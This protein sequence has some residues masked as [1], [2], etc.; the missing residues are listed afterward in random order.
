[1][2]NILNCGNNFVFCLIILQEIIEHTNLV[3]KYLQSININY[4]IMICNRNVL[5]DS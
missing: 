1:M 4:I 5:S 3:S 2:K